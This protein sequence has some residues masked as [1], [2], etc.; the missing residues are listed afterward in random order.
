LVEK[1]FSVFPG[2][3]LPGSS[4]GFTPEAVAAGADFDV[5]SWGVVIE[6][7]SDMVATYTDVRV[8]LSDATGAVVASEVETAIVLLPGTRLGTGGSA[9]V[10][11]APPTDVDVE[12]GSSQWL[13]RDIE[14]VELAE[15]EASRVAVTV[16]PAE[17]DQVIGFSISSDY[18]T[19]RRAWATTVFRN[20]SGDL[21]GGTG[22]E[23]DSNV[24]YPDAEPD[25][26]VFRLSQGE[27]RVG[28]AV[29]DIDV[30]QSEVFLDLVSLRE[31][32]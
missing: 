28:H 32:G 6:N 18:S 10:E 11:D 8:T 20:R 7:T 5:A 4:A 12:I 16:D 21:I 27:I 30:A 24:N 2:P 25:R 19:R 14:S 9:T 26:T 17:L 13:P 31:P 1:G 23:D 15:L 3:A 29:P 22:R